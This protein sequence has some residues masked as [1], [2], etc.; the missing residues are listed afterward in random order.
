MP[1]RSSAK[2]IRLGEIGSLLGAAD[3][4]AQIQR[5]VSIARPLFKVRKK[6]GAQ[7]TAAYV[8]GLGVAVASH[9][10]HRVFLINGEALVDL[11][12]EAGIEDGLI[13]LAK[14]QGP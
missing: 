5:G 12:C 2:L 14:K 8:E 10:T 6:S 3:F 13:V 4:Q 1:A 7:W 9:Q 11:A